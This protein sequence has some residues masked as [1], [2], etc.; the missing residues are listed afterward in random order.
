MDASEEESEISDNEEMDKTFDLGRSTS[1]HF[2]NQRELDDLIRDLGLTK[3]GAELLSSRLNEWNLLAEDCRST[4]YRKRH[5]EFGVYFDIS[6]DLCYCKDINGMFAAIGIEHKPEE[7]RLFIDSSTKSLKAVLLHNGN[8][9]PSLPVAYSVQMKE[10]YENVKRLLEMVNYDE[11]KWD[12]CGDFKM[13]AFLLGLQ[14]GYTKYSCFLCLWDSRADHEH[15]QKIEWPLRENLQPGKLNVIREPLVE[16]AKVLLP[17][18]HIKLGLIK[19]FVKALDHGGETFQEIR[20]MF[21]KLSE[22]KV[23]GGIFTGPQVRKMLKSVQLENVMSDV[24]KVAWCAFR[25][26]V[27]GFL[28]NNKDPNYKQLI[29]K[30]LDSYKNLGCRM[31]L[32]VH[33]L[34]SH[35]DFFRENLGNVSEEHGERFHQDIAAMEKRYQGRWDTAMMGDY[36]WSLVRN[37]PGTHS[38]KARSSVH[39]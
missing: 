39:F 12:V 32:K 28:G 8:Q 31:S 27:N 6:K 10:E 35:L 37:D 7:W 2:P 3:S 38:R 33:F 13:L 23:K 19:Q 21:P 15:Y 36:I 1:P 20:L 5:E 30:L 29:A 26:I 16:P 4:V 24:E 25:D 18:L 9:Y 14:G 17:P 34:H 22:A 11:F